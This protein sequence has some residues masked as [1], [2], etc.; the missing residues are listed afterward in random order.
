[1]IGTNDP[2]RT[3]VNFN[4]PKEPHGHLFLNVTVPEV[5]DTS[6]SLCLMSMDLTSERAVLVGR[7]P[8]GNRHKVTIELT[9]GEEN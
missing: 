8:F 9:T 4:D 5:T 6:F 1:M 7:D 2:D 3:T